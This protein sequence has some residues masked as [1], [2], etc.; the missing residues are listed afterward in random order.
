MIL[1]LSYIKTSQCYLLD[2]V[3][4]RNG[5]EYYLVSSSKRFYLGSDVLSDKASHTNK[6]LC[7]ISFSNDIWFLS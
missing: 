5:N 2:D 3:I 6:R 7:K 4:H 1:P